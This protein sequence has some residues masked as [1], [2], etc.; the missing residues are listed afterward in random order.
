MVV[1]TGN[2]HAG[3]CGRHPTG[4]LQKQ[5]HGAG[6]VG[7]PGQGGGLARCEGVATGRV[8]EGVLGALGRREDSEEG[9]GERDNSAHG[10]IDADVWGVW[11]WEVYRK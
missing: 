2:G 4:L 8:V 3:L 5:R 11:V 6:S 10:G 9:R 7:F 1:L